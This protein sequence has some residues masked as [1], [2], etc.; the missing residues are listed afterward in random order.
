MKS[1]NLIALGSLQFQH[2][3]RIFR[4][5]PDQLLKRCVTDAK[6]PGPSTTRRPAAVAATEPLEY[7]SPD[8][9]RF[10]TATPRGAA[11]AIWPALLRDS[12][13][14]IHAMASLCRDGEV[15]VRVE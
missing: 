3:A 12:A 2:F 9:L 10:L 8:H 15:L 4:E 1:E 5:F 11:D 13:E 14:N 7:E 6:R